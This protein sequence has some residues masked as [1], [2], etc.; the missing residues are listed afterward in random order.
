MVADSG[1]NLIP[2]P[3]NN[4]PPTVISVQRISTNW[5]RHFNIATFTN[6]V[7]VTNTYGSITLNP[8]DAPGG[9]SGTATNLTGAVTNQINALAL[10]QAQAVLGNLAPT[11]VPV[12]TVVS[13]GAGVTVVSN[14]V[15][16]V[17]TYTVSGIS[18][19]TLLG[20]AGAVIAGSNY[21]TS[22][23]SNNIAGSLNA[24]QVYGLGTVAGLSSN[25]VL[26]MAG[27][28]IAGSNYLTTLPGNIVTNGQ[29]NVVMGGASFTLTNA[30][31]TSATINL[32]AIPG[33][34]QSLQASPSGLVAAGVLLNNGTLTANAI[35]LNNGGVITGNGGNLTNTP[36][37]I[38]A[39]GANVTVTSSTNATTG[40]ITYNVASTGGGGGGGSGS[41]ALNAPYALS[42][43]TNLIVDPVNGNYQ[44]VILTNNTTV[45]WTNVSGAWVNQG[46]FVRLEVFAGTFSLTWTTP[47]LATNLFNPSQ[48]TTSN[49]IWN[50]YLI[51]K[52]AYG[53]AN[54]K[55]YQLQ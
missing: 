39:A 21:L 47:T 14:S 35:N 20:M 29:A 51:D 50:V 12:N 46:A 4:P 17:Q 28:A 32:E 25:A 33:I 42:S 10:A 13:A 41:G 3:I 53:T 49:G 52:V 19:N 16:G 11:N 2:N 43:N 36:G 23:S 40:Q 44:S 5:V 45:T 18:S 37:P 31:G 26:A 55:V 9:S 30:S 54:A 22:A 6:G 7:C 1:G 24:G 48:L 27:A 8:I 38:I 15:A 34:W